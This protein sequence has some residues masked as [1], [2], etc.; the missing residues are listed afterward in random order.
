MAWRS[1]LAVFASLALHG[2]VIGLVA[3]EKLRPPPPVATERDLPEV[4][5]GDT[6]DVETLLAKPVDTQTPAQPAG[7]AADPSPPAAADP[8]PAP[9]APEPAPAAR[10]PRVKPSSDSSEPTQPKK[11]RSRR[12]RREHAPR[13]EPA[14]STA[15]SA[16]ASAGPAPAA[17][18]AE[19]GG[20]TESGANTD[21]P[22]GVRRLDKAFVRAITAATHRDRI[23]TELPAGVVGKVLVR[24]SVDADGKLGEAQ[25]EPEVL[26][27]PLQHLVT[28]TQAMLKSGRF[29]LPSGLG[30]GE[31][32]LEVEVTLSDGVP[33]EDGDNPG[34][35]VSLGFEAPRRDHPGKAYFLLASGRRFEASVRLR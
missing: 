21:L 1:V 23:W 16:V 32:A 27:E 10:E 12:P 15:T 17:P 3:R 24:I 9:A 4:W 14:A 19:G 30:A 29:A 13:P 11:R 26:S 25:T 2:G 18:A 35:T 6:V 34:S 28:R 5:K 20:A 7:P 33:S 22:A 8:S 31:I